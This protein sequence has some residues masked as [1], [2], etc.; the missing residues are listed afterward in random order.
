VAEIVTFLVTG[1]ADKAFTIGAD[2][3][4]WGSPLFFTYETI[5]R[6]IAKRF[7]KKAD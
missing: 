5:W 3:I 2:E 7:P 4:L 6:K 1:S